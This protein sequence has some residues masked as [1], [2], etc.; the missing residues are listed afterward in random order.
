MVHCEGIME[1]CLNNL[2]RNHNWLSVVSSFG[3]IY[4]LGIPFVYNWICPIK[5][6]YKVIYE[7]W[8]QYSGMK[9]GMNVQEPILHFKF[10]Q[11]N[12]KC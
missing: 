9:V 1:M 10:E 8:I 3:S 6:P 11:K 2:L 12:D 7:R 5:V 4:L